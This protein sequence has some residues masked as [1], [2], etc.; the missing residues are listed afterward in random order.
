MEAPPPREGWGIPEP[1]HLSILDSPRSNTTDSPRPA[2]SGGAWGRLFLVSLSRP[3]APAAPPSVSPPH[4]A[5]CEGQEAGGGTGGGKPE[6]P[7]LNIPEILE[8]EG[9]RG[10]L[11]LHWE[12]GGGCRLAQSC[13]RATSSSTTADLAWRAATSTRPEWLER[14]ATPTTQGNNSAGQQQRRATSVHHPMSS[15]TR[16]PES[17]LGQRKHRPR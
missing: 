17:Y 1:P 3:L 15:R 14:R 2:T 10:G 8:V 5:F 12:E 11:R 7:Y 9:R 6:F 16:Q 4:K 13:A